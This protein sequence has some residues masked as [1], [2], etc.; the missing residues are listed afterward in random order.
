MNFQ[1]ADTFTAALTRLTGQEQK[2]V[3]TAAFDLQLSPERPGLQMHRLDNGRD[4]NFWSARV[5]QDIRI[6]IHKTEASFMLAYVDHHDKAYAW[7][8]RR[9]IEAHPRTNAIQIVEVH[10]R[11]EEA[12]PQFP[13]IAERA[14]EPVAAQPPAPALFAALTADELLDIGTPEDWVE[15]VRSWTED[16]FFTMSDRLPAE[17]AEALLDYAATGI[18]PQ[19]VW[20][21]KANAPF[22]HPDTLRRVI[23]IATSEDLQAA[24]DFPWDKWSVF[25]HPSQRDIVDRDFAGPARVTGSAGTGKT[26]VALHRA[27]RVVRE[28]A[29]ARVLLTTFSR[30]LANA[31]RAKLAILLTGDHGMIDRVSVASFEDAAGDLYQLATGRR[32]VVA[33]PDVQQAALDR[34]IAAQRYAELPAR[35]VWAEWRQVVDGWGIAYLDA[36]ASVPRVGRRNRLGAKQREVL[37]PVFMAARQTLKARGM[38]TLC[39]LYADVA[40][41]YATRGDKLYTHVIV[42]E[43]QDLGV[44]ELRMMAALAGG[45]GA[46]FFAGD[47]G[48]RIFQHPFSWKSLGV[49]VRGRSSS[50]RINYRTSRQ[51]REAADKLL[52][53]KVTD[54]DGI[55]DSRADAQSVF[56]GPPPEIAECEND[57][58]EADA[59]AAFLRAASDAEIAPFEMGV[60][61]RSDE[62]LA[63]ARAAIGLTGLACRQLSD[64][65]EDNPEC[66]A[67]GTMHFAKGLE[68]KAVAVMACDDEALPLQT[69]I[70]EATDE[71]ELREVFDTERHLFYVACTRARDR[72]HVSGVKPASEFLDDLLD[73]GK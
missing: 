54:V 2:Q 16:R 44:N 38:V 21:Q 49:D 33:A 12:Q 50:L 51:I 71:D 53:P 57:A 13:L 26:I 73:A 70:D 55:E 46:L 34:A 31:L 8:E 6:I 48:Q 64:R 24:L 67:L 60:F 56:E 30:P 39:Q 25:L 42:D 69:R 1:I 23:T 59:V 41:H 63:R 29:H 72:L 22:A 36:Y 10:E 66:V 68:F 47:L 11:I 5:N 35:F 20:M 9:R 52:P 7:A 62:Q 19:A 4:P 15:D 28:D 17:V 40:A 37:W 65:V 45:P 58:A 27:A 18:V 43:A 3:K 61:V 14:P 32:P